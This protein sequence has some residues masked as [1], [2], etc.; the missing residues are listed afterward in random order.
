[1][2]HETSGFVL[3]P[4]LAGDCATVGELDLDRVLLMNDR[5]YPWFI[6]VP[7]R[8]GLRELHELEEADLAQFWRESATVGRALM[9]HFRGDKFNVAALGNQVPQLHVHHI[10]RHETDAAWPRPVWGAV[11]PVPYA[12]EERERV[13]AET[14]SLL[15]GAGLRLTW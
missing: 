1:M 11:A 5:N 3:H 8:P 12:G 2:S 7:R 4:R 13:L 15:A 6:L 10:V 9:R 14:R